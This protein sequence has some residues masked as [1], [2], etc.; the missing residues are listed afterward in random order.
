ME[1]K[2]AI[3]AL[4]GT[5][6]DLSKPSMAALAYVLRHP[7]MWPEKYA[8]RGW[9]FT[10]CRQC[11]MGLTAVLWPHAMQLSNTTGRMQGAVNPFSLPTI[12]KLFNLNYAQAKD[13]FVLAPPAAQESPEKFA[14][15]LDLIG[16]AP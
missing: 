6:P 15:F 10:D 4:R 5:V 3:R 11:A 1:Y 2:T 7:Q 8:K 16:P 13:I 14:D 9:C 12:S